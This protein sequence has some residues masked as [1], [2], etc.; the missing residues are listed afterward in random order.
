MSYKE[1]ISIVN[2]RTHKLI[3]FSTKHV[4]YIT[5]RGCLLTILG[6]ENFARQMVKMRN[7]LN[8]A[9][10]PIVITYCLLYLLCFRSQSFTLKQHFWVK[11]HDPV[12][13]IQTHSLDNVFADSA[14]HSA[15]MFFNYKVSYRISSWKSA[16]TVIKKCS[17]FA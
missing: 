9:K 17:L 3:N 11:T 4:Q 1:V 10:I 13:E 12:F 7:S 16:C 15:C 8:C 6:L 5:N 14:F 2:E